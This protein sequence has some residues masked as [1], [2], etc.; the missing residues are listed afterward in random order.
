MT[1]VILCLPCLKDET[2]HPYLSAMRAELPHI[3]L[4]LGHR[5]KPLI[6]PRMKYSY[7]LEPVVNN[8]RHS[9]PS[10]PIPLTTFSKSFVPQRS[11]FSAESS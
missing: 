11:D 2:C 3:A 7:L 6:W 1:G 5:V 10:H 8:P 4:T 9:L